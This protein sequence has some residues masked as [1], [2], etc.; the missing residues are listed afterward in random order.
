MDV[1][2]LGEFKDTIQVSYYTEDAS[3]KAGSRYE[4]VSGTLVFEP[5][6]LSKTIRVPLISSDAWSTTLEFK[7]RLHDPRGCDLGRYL[8]VCRVKVIDNDCFPTNR[9]EEPIK[10]YGPGNLI[11]NGV[12]AIDLIVEYCKFNYTLPGITDKTWATLTIDQLQNLYYLLTIDLLKYVADDVLGPSPGLPLL[13]TSSKELT[14]LLVGTLLVVPYGILNLLEYWKSQMKTSEISIQF[15]QENMFRKFTNYSEASR[16][17]IK[18]SEMGLVMV[19][20]VPDMVE[21][22]Y[23]RL[24]QLLKYLGKL[25]VSSYFILT[26]NPD[27]EVPLVVSASAIALFVTANYRKSLACNEAVARKQADIVEVVQETNQKYRL[28][29]DYYMRPQVQVVLEDRTS[30]L[31]SASVPAKGARVMNDYFPGWISTGLVAFYLFFGG[32]AVVENQLQIGAFLATIN[33][34]KDIGDSFKDIFTACLDVGKAIG[35]VARVTEILNLPTNL[36]EMKRVN[37]IR[38][39]MTKEFRTPAKLAELR[40]RFGTRYG[41]DAVPILLQDVCFA[42]PDSD[43]NVI[44]NVNLSVQPGNLVAVVGNLRGGKSTFI[45]LLGNVLL[46]TG[47][48]YFVPSF[49]RILHVSDVPTLLKGS[50]WKNLAIGRDYWQDVQFETDRIVRICRRIG[51]GSAIMNQLEVTAAAFLAGTDEERDTSWQEAL[52]QSDR[53]LIHLARAF[54]YNPEVLVMNRPTLRLPEDTAK[55]VIQVIKEFVD[56]KGVELPKQELW[57]RRPRTAFVSFV[58]LGG[59]QAADIVLKVDAGCVSTV[60]GA[61]VSSDLIR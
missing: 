48:F 26:E 3:A 18:E 9:F 57:K 55:I 38:R 31:R 16:G 13:I 45:K 36:S 41:S 23:M 19:Q 5:Q 56:Q 43:K 47:G 11:A 50:L 44:R 59:V 52:S 20:D 8:F 25:A 40:L 54:I 37:R 24:V 2:R 6:V 58:R 60:D 34:V 35:P 32:S 51:L 53:V 28:I 1:V 10:Q 15:M 42:Y 12:P 7:V 4:A 33:A 46:P 30:S 29:A 14:L 49:L 27:A 22:G 61:D 39:R 17:K 21:N